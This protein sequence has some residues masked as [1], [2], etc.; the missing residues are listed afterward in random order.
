VNSIY[1][2]IYYAY[3]RILIK[4]ETLTK[5]QK[6]IL[7]F[8]AR[9]TEQ[10][11][12]A[13][14]LEE[15]ASHFRLSSA[16]TVHKHLL[17]L[18]EKGFIS[19]QTGRSRAIL[20]T[21]AQSPAPES[22]VALPLLGR[23]AAGQPIEAILDHET[24]TVPTHMVRGTRAFALQVKGTSMVDENIQDGDYIVV[25]QADAAEQGDM[26]VA[27]IDNDSATLK[28]FYREP[29]HIRLQP[30]NPEMAPI[31]VKNQPFRIQ[32]IVIGLL[33]KYA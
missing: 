6:E 30:A 9:F 16:S 33:R 32:G 23:I 7:D 15:I 5:R 8:L 19:R 1:I 31:I 29:D 2:A 25:E 13:P 17:N 18:E 21:D 3:I 14:S 27:L 22:T 20:V 12:Y 4:M 11:G 26:V 28:R 24:L 10:H